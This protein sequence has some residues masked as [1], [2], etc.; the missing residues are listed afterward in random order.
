MEGGIE[1]LQSLLPKIELVIPLH[2]RLSTNNLVDRISNE[3]VANP[4]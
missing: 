1:I 4:T 2:V 3:G